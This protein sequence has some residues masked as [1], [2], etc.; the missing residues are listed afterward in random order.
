[1]MSRIHHEFQ[2][3]SRVSEYITCFDVHHLVQSTLCLNPFVVVISALSAT[4]RHRKTTAIT[5]K[6]DVNIRFANFG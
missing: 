6:D 4:V 3:T 5:F 1:M 2:N